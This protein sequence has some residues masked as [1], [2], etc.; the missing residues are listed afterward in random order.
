MKRTGPHLVVSELAHS[1]W[2]LSADDES[3][4]DGAMNCRLRIRRKFRLIWFLMNVMKWN[5]FEEG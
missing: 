2:V 4:G 3:E 1:G 5:C